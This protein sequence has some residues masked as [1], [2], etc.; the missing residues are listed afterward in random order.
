MEV[1]NLHQKLPPSA[2]HWMPETMAKRTGV[3]ELTR[4]EIPPTL[5]PA[6]PGDY[7]L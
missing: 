3:L 6:R 4:P 2:E 5:S 1:M 7:T